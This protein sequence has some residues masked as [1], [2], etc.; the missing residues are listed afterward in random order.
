MRIQLYTYAFIVMTGAASAQTLVIPQ[1]ADGNGWQ[2]ELVITNTGA[3]AS[4][5][6]LNFFPCV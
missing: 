1:I 6:R 5:L 3:S 4:T 2:T